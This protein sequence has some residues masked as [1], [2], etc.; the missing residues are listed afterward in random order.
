MNVGWISGIG[1][2]SGFGRVATGSR[3]QCDYVLDCSAWH[4]DAVEA[5][6]RAMGEGF[7]LV[8]ADP[9]SSLAARGFLA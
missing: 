9:I 2:F 8:K 6:V 3:P 1:R 4:A 5:T 7:P